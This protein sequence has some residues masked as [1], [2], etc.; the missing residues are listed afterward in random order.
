MLHA[1]SRPVVGLFLTDAA[2]DDTAEASARYYS[3]VEPLSVEAL[4]GHPIDLW[5]DDSKRGTHLELSWE[6]RPR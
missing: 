6:N 3:F 5:L 2:L 1:H 4:G